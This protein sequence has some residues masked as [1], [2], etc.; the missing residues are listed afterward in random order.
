MNTNYKQLIS[1]L[2][3][4]V[5][6][7][8]ERALGFGGWVRRNNLMQTRFRPDGSDGRRPD[9]T[10][11]KFI[12][13]SLFLTYNGSSYSS[14]YVTKILKDKFGAGWMKTVCDLYGIAAGDYTADFTPRDYKQT[15]SKPKPYTIG[16]EADVACIPQELVSLTYDRSRN[17]TL[18]NFLCATFGEV[19]TV[20][21]WERYRVGNGYG[22]QVLFWD[23]DRQGRCRGGKMM[24]YRPDGHRD[25]DR[26]Y[27]IIGIGSDLKRQG[28]IEQ[29]AKLV[30][31]LFG[32]HILEAYPLARVGLVESEK[33][34][35]IASFF[36]PETVWLATGG[37]TQKLDRAV[38][39]LAGRKV[40]VFPDCDATSQWKNKFSKVR[41]FTVSEICRDYC[42]KN[43]EKWAKAD[44]A[45][46]LIQEY[47]TE[48]KEA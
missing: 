32:E 16:D 31:C 2:E 15:Y 8:P 1:R 22:G 24:C 36:W 18:F 12:N 47:H 38:A 46:I 10:V 13:D 20:Q 5:F 21:A 42:R 14:A 34:A 9:K 6:G 28:K 29:D 39:L 37:A 11:L 26:P 3:F 17:C 19:A 33:T 45:D 35:L 4:A 43:G 30:D 41:G 7:S 44:L 27:G 25:K 23:Y 40:S 48:P